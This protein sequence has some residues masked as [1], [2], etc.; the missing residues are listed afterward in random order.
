WII[1]LGQCDTATQGKRSK[2]DG[3]E[4]CE[5]HSSPPKD[6]SFFAEISADPAFGKRTVRHSWK[7]RAATNRVW[8]E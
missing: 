7:S 6:F 1:L 2:Q 5:A 8:N 3:R 4:T